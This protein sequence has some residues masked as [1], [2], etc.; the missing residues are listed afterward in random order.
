MID[1]SDGFMKD[2]PKNRLRAQDVHKIV[3]VFFR[4]VELPRFHDGVSF[5]PLTFPFPLSTI[6]APSRV[7]INFLT[8]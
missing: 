2:G 1:A 6:D 3:D 5:V 7:M 4:Q 8:I